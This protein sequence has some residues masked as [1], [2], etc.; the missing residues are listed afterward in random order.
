M[1]LSQ[2]SELVPQ[3]WYASWANSD[4][5]SS[6]AVFNNTS[7]LH[8]CDALW[9]YN[10]DTV[11]HD[12]QVFI[13]ADNHGNSLVGVVRVPAGAGVTVPLVEAIRTLFG[14][15]LALAALQSGEGISAAPL[16]AVSAGHTLACYAQGGW[17]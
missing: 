1:P 12:V 15:T 8:R 17:L 14:T 9:W 4:G 5:T 13:D 3:S 16:A 6:K 7:A 2:L 10:D 11:E